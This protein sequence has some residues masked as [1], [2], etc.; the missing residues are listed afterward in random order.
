MEQLLD[1]VTAEFKKYFSVVEHEEMVFVCS[2]QVQKVNISSLLNT[3][4]GDFKL[5]I[6]L[7]VVEGDN[8]IYYGQYR[9]AR[10]FTRIFPEALSPRNE[11]GDV[12]SVCGSLQSALNLGNIFEYAF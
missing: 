5:S 6:E 7:V 8:L 3:L 2:K 10:E 12:W 4:C 9:G 11:C 1:K